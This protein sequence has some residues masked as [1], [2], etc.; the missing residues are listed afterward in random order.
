MGR[1]DIFAVKL[2]RENGLEWFEEKIAGAREAVKLTRED[3]EKLISTY[4]QKLEALESTC[5][6]RV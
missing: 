6:L 5:S 1:H 3:L 2:I 4:K